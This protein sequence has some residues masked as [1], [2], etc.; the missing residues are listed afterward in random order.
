MK[1]SD[2]DRIVTDAFEAVSR[3]R[4][5][6]DLGEAAQMTK[7]EL[8]ARELRLQSARVKQA[9]VE[10]VSISRDVRRAAANLVQKSR[11]RRD[12]KAT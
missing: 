3:E 1:T 7:S 5:A 6:N 9:S 8:D 11:S 2:L 12:G 4:V 10:T